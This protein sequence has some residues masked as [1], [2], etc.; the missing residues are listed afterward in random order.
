MIEL[1]LMTIPRGFAHSSRQSMARGKA[2]DTPQ[3][4]AI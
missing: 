3:K 2:Q 4:I 1:D